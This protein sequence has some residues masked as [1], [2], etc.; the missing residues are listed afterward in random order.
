MRGLSPQADDLRRHLDREMGG[1]P[2]WFNGC[3]P[4][5]QQLVDRP[6]VVRIILPMRDMFVWPSQCEFSCAT[7]RAENQRRR[8]QTSGSAG[9]LMGNGRPLP[10][11]HIPYYYIDTFSPRGRGQKGKVAP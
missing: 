6:F 9:F 5:E 4:R 7:L 1:W 10:L 11:L 8:G 3:L 2:K